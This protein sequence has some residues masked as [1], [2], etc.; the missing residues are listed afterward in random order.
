MLS[1][2]LFVNYVVLLP[3]NMTDADYGRIIRIISPD[4]IAVT[5]D[6]SNIGKKRAHASNIN[7]KMR[8]IPHIKFASTSL[9]AK[10]LG[11]E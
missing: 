2:L 6:D 7:A 3:E 10:Q 8:V 11:I 9:V 1:S 5:K 4:I